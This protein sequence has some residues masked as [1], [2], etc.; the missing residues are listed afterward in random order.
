M[1][2]LILLTVALNIGFSNSIE[3][4]LFASCGCHSH[5]VMMRNVGKDIEEDAN[6]SWVQ[7]SIFEFGFGLFQVPK[8]W[9]QV[10]TYDYDA[11][12]SA[13]NWYINVPIDFGRPWDIRGI[14]TYLSI[15]IRNQ[16]VCRK[17]VQS[18]AFRSFKQRNI[19]LKCRNPNFTITLMASLLNSTTVQYS[20]WPIADGYL[21]SFNVPANPSYV[22]KTLTPFSLL[23]K[24]CFKFVK[25]KALVYQSIILQI[26]VFDIEAKQI[27][28]GSRSGILFEPV[29][30]ISNRIKHFGCPSYMP[31]KLLKMIL[32]TLGEVN[33][34]VIWQTNSDTKTY[35]VNQTIP[36]NV[37]ICSW[38]PMKYLLAHRNI[39][40]IVTHG[41][42]NTINELLFYGVPIIGIPLQVNNFYYSDIIVS[43]KVSVNC[44]QCQI[45]LHS[46]NSELRHYSDSQRFWLQ[47]A[48]RH[49]VALRKN[50]RKYFDLFYRSSFDYFAVPQ[51]ASIFLI[52]VT[53]FCVVY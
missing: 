14:I 21:T 32:T 50:G 25:N 1:L 23:S 19:V 20:N 9:N 4:C 18:Q 7:S 48:A 3:V 17:M 31:S 5:D 24:N 29:R 34:L 42:I 15:L 6:I 26:D 53:L 33:H 37:V 38:V 39:L 52:V 2:K 44:C 12:G 41:G 11:N 43:I 22:A 45:N 16:K 28:Y 51:L 47:W 8:H 30:P 49:G 35:L 10:R 36:S 46:S 13:L 27:I 40:Y